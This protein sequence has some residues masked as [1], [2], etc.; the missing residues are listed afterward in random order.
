[1]ISPSAGR[2]LGFFPLNWTFFLAILQF[3]KFQINFRNCSPTISQDGKVIRFTLAK[4]GAGNHTYHLHLELQFGISALAD[5]TCTLVV[6]SVT[7]NIYP[8]MCNTA[9]KWDSCVAYWDINNWKI[10]KMLVKW[11]LSSL[12]LKFFCMILQSMWKKPMVEWQTDIHIIT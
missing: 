11:S 2:N 8:S 4:R 1:M 5:V 7:V 12:P 3:A 10:E 9:S 6:H